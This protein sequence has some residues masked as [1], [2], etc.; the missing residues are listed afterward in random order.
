MES[1]EHSVSHLH[2]TVNLAILGKVDD[3]ADVDKLTRISV[4]EHNEVVRKNRAIL[5]LVVDSLKF[6]G[7]Y[8][9]PLSNE[10][11]SINPGVF[12]DLINIPLKMDSSLK[13]HYASE[14][15]FREEI[16][17]IKKE[18][19]VSIL[20]ICKNKI[21]E[22]VKE[23]K[24]LAVI[25][26]EGVD[27]RD[28]D[29]VA[30][31]LRYIWKG[32][33]V[34]RFW[35]FVHPDSLEKVLLKDLD[36]LTGSSQ[37]KLIAQVYDGTTILD[38]VKKGLPEV[39]R[40]SYCNAHLISCY[41]R[42]PIVDIV[43]AVCQN[44]SARAFFNSL[45]GIY[46]YF[47]KT[48]QRMATLERVANRR[49][50]RVPKC[51]LSR[52]KRKV[53]NSI[54]ELKDVMVESCQVLGTSMSPEA[55]CGASNIRRT[56]SDPRFLYWLD[57]FCKVMP[58]INLQFSLLSKT[59]DR[60]RFKTS[61]DS[62]QILVFK[63]KREADVIEKKFP[64]V[65]MAVKEVCDIILTEFSERLKFTAH[66]HA[67]KLLPLSHFPVLGQQF[68]NKELSI[69]GD[70]YTML[71]P[72]HL[73]TELLVLYART[74]LGK[75]KTLEGLLRDI[76]DNSLQSTLPETLKLTS[77]VLTTPMMRKEPERQFQTF[78][79]I[80]SF[81]QCPLPEDG[82]AAMAMMSIEQQMILDM[83]D[84]N[85]QVINNFAL[86]SGWPEFTFK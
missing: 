43:R 18:L 52:F 24:Y 74:D 19:L 25:C 65:S 22:E 31:I 69:V 26:Y 57:F 16:D 68:P 21:R 10:D 23:V 66:I 85:E 7:K 8:K 60:K 32:E 37:E 51:V 35:G 75:T 1:H 58:H 17:T 39:I 12:L 84:F 3:S 55:G 47:T 63:L 72:R 20:S 62:F 28:N 54:F 81:L 86:E 56:L 79:R 76:Y 14:A 53:I 40:K 27:T 44:K 29:Q 4:S 78:S 50:K 15:V 34:E 49:P 82:Y 70:A 11:I 71:H 5:S 83:P 33:P 46:N 30:I 73:E 64:D 77:L 48:P 38:A 41:V 42:E 9:L 2:N 67:Q 36:L 13:A 45:S 80:Q 6:C 59:M 61:F